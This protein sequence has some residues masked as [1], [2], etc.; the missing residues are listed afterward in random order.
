M[1]DG[2]KRQDRIILNQILI[3]IKSFVNLEMKNGR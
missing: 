3:C 2:A 1:I